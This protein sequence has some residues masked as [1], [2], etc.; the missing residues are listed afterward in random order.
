MSKKH[1][2]LLWRVLKIWA[3]CLILAFC[4]LGVIAVK[5]VGV[6]VVTM[7]REAS[8]DVAKSSKDTFK[9]EQNSLVYDAEGNE[10]RMFPIL[11]MKI[12]QMRQSWRLFRQKIRILPHIMELMWREWRVQDFPSF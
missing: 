8:K 6:P 9:A 3:T 5:R 1:N 7:Y 2:G 10:I 11:I 12:F 4:V